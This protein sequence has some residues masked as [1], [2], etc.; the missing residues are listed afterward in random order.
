MLVICLLTLIAAVVAVILIG[1]RR[2]SEHFEILEEALRNQDIY[3]NV[4]YP[5]QNVIKEKDGSLTMEPTTRFKRSAIGVQCPLN[6]ECTWPLYCNIRGAT[7]TCQLNI[8]YR[9]QSSQDPFYKRRA[10]RLMNDGE[11]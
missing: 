6:D 2:S 4:I 7:K 10:K 8:G 5:T 1:C 11:I 3:F 9:D